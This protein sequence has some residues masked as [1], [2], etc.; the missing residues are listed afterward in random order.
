MGITLNED[1]IYASYKAKDWW[2]E[3]NEQIFE[4]SGAAGT[5]KTT[6]C[7]YILQ[8]LGLDIKD[9][10]FVAFTGK[11]ASQLARNGLPGKTVHSYFYEYVKRPYRD[12]NGKFVIRPNGKPKMVGSF[13]LVDRL[14]GKPKCIIIDESP[15][16]NQEM[17]NDICSFGVP[18]MALGDRNQL[19]PVFGKSVFLVNPDVTLHQIMRQNEGNPIIWLA[20]QV[21]DGKMPPYGVYKNSCVIKKEDLTEFQLKNADIVLTGTNKL[22][23]QI[24]DLFREEYLGFTRLEIPYLG[25]KIMCRRNNWNRTIGDNLYLT[26]GLTGFIEYVDRE[27][28]NGKTIKLDFR[29]D[30]TNKV[31]RNTVVDYGHMMRNEDPLE[32]NSYK[33]GMDMFEFAYAITTYSSQGSQWDNVVG[34]HEDFLSSREDRMRHLYTMITRA[35]QQI[36]LVI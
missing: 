30:F 32:Q 1:Q 14:K 20:H 15:Q 3:G 11:A 19:P 22:R 17:K 10:A 7:R 35:A 25:E 12:E 8:E 31:F 33:L 16:I 9:C 29:P 28:F 36:C 21:L 6:C 34:L 27:S 24:N 5:G 13:E 26:N 23:F 2:K 18:I 4:I